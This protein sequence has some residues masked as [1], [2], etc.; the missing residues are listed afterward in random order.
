[1][2]QT[3]KCWSAIK[4]PHGQN[5][6]INSR[7]YLQTC[8]KS[9]GTFISPYKHSRSA[10]NLSTALQALQTQ[11]FS[12][13]LKPPVETD[14]PVNLLTMCKLLASCQL[15]QCSPPTPSPHHHHPR[16]NCWKLNL[17]YKDDATAI[18]SPLPQDISL[19][20]V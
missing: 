10:H 8:S 15:L 7:T 12:R 13:L 19:L 9:F 1:M 3:Q 2:Q 20:Q 11:M 14:M 18:P 17:D 4:N 5:H 16:G 6:T